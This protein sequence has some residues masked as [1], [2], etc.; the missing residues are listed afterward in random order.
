MQLS[1]AR[2]LFPA[3]PAL[4]QRSSGEFRTIWHRGRRPSY[5]RIFEIDPLKD[6]RWDAL[7]ERHPHASIFH[8]RGWLEALHRTYG[9]VPVAYTD[10][11]PASELENVIVFCRVDSWLTGKRL[12]SLPFSDHCDP[13]TDQSANDRG[14]YHQVLHCLEQSEWR[15][16]EIRWL[17]W[18]NP[19]LEQDKTYCFHQIDLRPSLDLLFRAF[20]K[21]STQRK[22]KRAQGE[23]LIVEQGTSE[24]HL[25]SFYE[26]QLLTRRRHGLP[27][28][29][30]QWF[31]N[32]ASCLGDRM[33]VLVAYRNRQPAAAILTLR[34]KD[35]LV[36]KY[37]C[38]DPRFH[39]LG[40]MH[41]LFW[42]AIGNAKRIG[43]L[44]FDLGRSDQE[45]LGL[46]KFKDRWGAKRSTI[47]VGR[48][49][50]GVSRWGGDSW[51][52]RVMGSV[53]R[54]VPDPILAGVGG[55]LYKHL[56]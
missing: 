44:Q 6:A 32:L 46:I 33:M 55:L 12:V 36:Y 25:D 48:H 9:Y 49:P 17:H 4:D 52:L 21:D 54:S 27:P 28:Q 20:H 29:P 23:K 15:Y 10:S 50:A 40:A 22:I 2:K 5:V 51:K 19:V 43:L 34:F 30:R 35:T 16:I 8:S 14:F 45:D 37:G 38:S 56:G 26:L 11:G 39:N 1:V 31:R 18:P 24:S 41:L 42:T 7:L 53:F 13:L 3:D 47:V